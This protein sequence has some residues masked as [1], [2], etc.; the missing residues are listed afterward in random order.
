MNKPLVSVII[1]TCNRAEYVKKALDSVLSQTY[2]NIEVVVL[3]DGSTDNTLE[4]ISA[5]KDKDE[6]VIVL[7]NNP[8]LG[9]VESLNK[10]IAL[11]KG[12]YIARIDDDDFWI[13]SEKLNKQ[14][15]FLENNKEHVL[16]GGGSIWIDEKGKEIIRLLL[17][18]KDDDIRNRILS[19]NCFV[20]SAVVFKKSDFKKV[21]GYNYERFGYASDWSLWLELGKLGKF[22]NFPE[23]FTYYLKWD[24]NLSNFKS[25]NARDNMRNQIRLR[26]Y[27]RNDYPGYSKA[28]FLGW[29]YYVCSFTPF[30]DKFRPIL[31]KFKKLIFK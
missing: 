18:E 5:Y 31:V 24:K 27:Y 7:N 22:Y 16:V 4:T 2:K 20:H 12:E 23:Y 14:V 17:P 30:Y 13:D 19:D 21:G 29:M 8:K 9:F 1:T 28:F 15:E 6:R 26:N 10:G 25:K 3:N 11:A